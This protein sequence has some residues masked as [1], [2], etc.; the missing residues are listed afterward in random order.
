[1]IE[2]THQGTHFILEQVRYHG[3]QGS[4]LLST[5]VAQAGFLDEPPKIEQSVLI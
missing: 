4:S 5:K 3:Y 2:K 1:M